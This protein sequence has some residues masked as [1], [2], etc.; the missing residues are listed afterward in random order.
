MIILQR[1]KNEV[2]LCL[3]T[4]SGHKEPERLCQMAHKLRC[5]MKGPQEMVYISPYNFERYGVQG[6]SFRLKVPIRD[7]RW[8]NIRNS[9]EVPNR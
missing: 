3:C 7:G 6:C 2:R 8:E 1:R 5:I 4:K 9:G